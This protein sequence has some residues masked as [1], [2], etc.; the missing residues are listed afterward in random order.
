MKKIYILLL[1]LCLSATSRAQFVDATKGL[2]IAPSAEMEQSGTFMFSGS[3]LNKQY[4][5]YNPKSE[6]EWGYNTAG[7][8]LSITFWSRL[9]VAYVC[10]IFNGKWNPNA[11][12][13]RAKIMMNQDRHFAARVQALKE[14]EFGKN[15]VPSVVFGISDPVSG[16]GGEYI[17]SD[18]SKGNGFFNRMYVAL[19]KHF[20]T[21]WGVVG[22][23]AAFQYTLRKDFSKTGPCAAVTW[24]PVWLNQPDS[25]LSSFRLIAEFDAKDFNIG[26]S[27]SVWRDHFEAW[28]CMEGCRYPSAG[29]RFKQVLH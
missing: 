28:V 20:D 13:Y 3:F 15:W 17:G 29:L 7:Y 2:L 10:T 14:N 6:Y 23:H 22:A 16:K 19:C 26:L 25:F 12:S 8:G 24:D 1:L 18:V 4:L 27:T 5:P 11:K 9:E 21:P